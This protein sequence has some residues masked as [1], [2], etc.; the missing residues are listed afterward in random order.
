MEYGFIDKRI[1]IDLTE[2]VIKTDVLHKYFCKY[3]SSRITA[4]NI[5]CKNACESKRYD[6]D[7]D[8]T[9]MR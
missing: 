3:I 1:V 9:S 6:C 8:K 2:S 5:A 4:S 7:K